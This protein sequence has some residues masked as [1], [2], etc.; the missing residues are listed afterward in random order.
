MTRNYSRTF[1]NGHLS[2]KATFFCG[3]SIHWLLFKPLYNGHFILS[4]RWPLWR[5][6]TVVLSTNWTRKTWQ[7]CLKSIVLILLRP[8]ALNYSNQWPN[9]EG[10]PFT[11]LGFL[12]F[13]H[14]FTILILLYYVF[15]ATVLVQLK[16]WL[17]IKVPVLWLRYHDKFILNGMY[18]RSN[19]TFE[20]TGVGE[21]VSE[22]NSQH[23]SFV[24]VISVVYLTEKVS[25]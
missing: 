19:F 13:S 8:L 10:P 11:T 18:K 7:S 12:R 2:T 25:I 23:W 1:T 21:G 3:H 9:H 20:V 6:S 4:P 15:Y 16:L 14:Y 22:E 17:R 5:G 24:I